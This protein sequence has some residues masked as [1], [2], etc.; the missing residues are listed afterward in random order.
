MEPLGILCA[1]TGADETSYG[2]QLTGLDATGVQSTQST[3]RGPSNYS[4][5]TANPQATDPRDVPRRQAPFPSKDCSLASL[6]YPDWTIDGISFTEKNGDLRFRGVHRASESK[7]HCSSTGEMNTAASGISSDGLSGFLYAQCV[8]DGVAADPLRTLPSVNATYDIKTRKILLQHQWT[9]G[10]NKGEHSTIFVAVGS[11]TLSLANT[12]FIKGSLTE[13][14][15]L[16]PAII[17]PPPNIDNPGCIPTSAPSWGL[18]GFSY[19][20]TSTPLYFQNGRALGP[21]PVE[22]LEVTIRNT[23]N[24]L[25][26]RCRNRADSINLFYFAYPYP[27]WHLC[28]QPEPSTVNAYA[29]YPIRTYVYIDRLN[30][31]FGVNQTWYCAGKD[32]NNP[33][34]VNAFATAPNSTAAISCSS[35]PFSQQCANPAVVASSS[36]G[37]TP[38][39]IWQCTNNSPS[40]NLAGTMLSTSPLP[41]TALIVSPDVDSVTGIAQ[42]C[43][44]LSVTRGPLAWIIDNF[45]FD[46]QY[47]TNGIQLQGRWRL[48]LKPPTWPMVQPRWFYPWGADGTGGWPAPMGTELEEK[49]QGAWK[50]NG[51]WVDSFRARV[52]GAELLHGA[53][54]KQK[55]MAYVEMVG[56]WYCDDR[57]PDHP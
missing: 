12:T 28:D 41:P 15:E 27:G 33:V 31:V 19:N 10:D 45:Q 2:C 50:W 22:T 38:C 47:Y 54:G 11:A 4:S 17:P 53:P 24:G 46:A 29:P 40:P 30:N 21:T 13:P 34:R 26:V 49:R 23:A 5:V 43:T 20:L 36:N 7:F 51:N 48:S 32:D 55:G 6:T 8:L 25:T 9:C 57:D 42:S 35:G 37:S 18:E 44:A 14:V 56:V 16:T 39:L 3:F 1:L 52:V